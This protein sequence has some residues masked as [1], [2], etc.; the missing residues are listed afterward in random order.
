VGPRRPTT[1]TALASEFA[2]VW[3]LVRVPVLPSATPHLAYFKSMLTLF[4][5]DSQCLRRKQPCEYPTE[6]RR[7]IRKNKE[8]SAASASATETASAS[9]EPT[10][11]FVPSDVGQPPQEE[12]SASTS[13]GRGRR[14]RT[15]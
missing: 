4:G 8:Q 13:R 2:F 9:E 5:F 7:G 6:S 11:R 3:A 14:K 12:P 15:D 1:R 10:V